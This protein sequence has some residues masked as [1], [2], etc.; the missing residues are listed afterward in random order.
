MVKQ[1]TE[2]KKKGHVT[3]PNPLAKVLALSPYYKPKRVT[4]RKG[5]NR[6]KIV[7]TRH[8]GDHHLYAS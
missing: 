8:P 1:E 4:N 7:G 5:Y 6:K 3:K 2:M